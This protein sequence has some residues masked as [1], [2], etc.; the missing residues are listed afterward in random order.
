M[1]LIGAGPSYLLVA[2]EQ[3]AATPAR[4]KRAPRP[5]CA[6]LPGVPGPEPVFIS[7]LLTKV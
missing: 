6:R 5:R 1:L 4:A 7:G 2:A 3:M